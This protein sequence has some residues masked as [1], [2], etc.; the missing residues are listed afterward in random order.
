MSVQV[1]TKKKV[2]LLG[3]YGVG[4]TSLVRRFVYNKFE[5]KYLS[6][7][8]VHISRK[9]VHLN[10]SEINKFEKE[11]DL[12]IWDI[13]NIEKFDSVTK[14]Y[15]NGAHGAIIV[16]DIT[17]PNTIIQSIDYANIFLELNPKAKIIFVGNK[18][19]LSDTIQFDKEKYISNFKSYKTNFSFSSAK[20]GE[21]VEEIFNILGEKLSEEL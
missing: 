21:N 14:S 8:G 4:K 16:T 2:C 7:I 3:S 1:N 6:T 18:F 11:I 9:T 15:I 13:A 12:F 19:D 5:E 20:T 10:E 17:R